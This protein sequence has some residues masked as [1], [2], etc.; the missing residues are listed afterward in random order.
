MRE[1]KTAEDLWVTVSEN[2]RGLYCMKV[3]DFDGNSQ[4]LTMSETDV[5]L[6]F[7]GAANITDKLYDLEGRCDDLENELDDAN[8]RLE[9]ADDEVHSLKATI[10]EAKENVAKALKAA[11]IQP[12]LIDGMIEDLF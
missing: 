10:A 2:R 8:D 6:L 11:G 9:E 12:G 4:E 1:V 3:T 7:S 5:N